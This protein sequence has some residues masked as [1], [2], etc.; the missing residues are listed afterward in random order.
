VFVEVRERADAPVSH[1][2]VQVRTLLPSLRAATAIKLIHK[3][4]RLFPDTTL[5]EALIRSGDTLLAIVEPQK[6]KA[7]RVKDKE[8]ERDKPMA[9][10]L[11][12]LSKQ[13]ENMKEFAKDMK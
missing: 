4:N 1:L 8:R 3:G 11:E 13:Q 9:E 5:E 2:L 7:H 12:F 6:S 10:M